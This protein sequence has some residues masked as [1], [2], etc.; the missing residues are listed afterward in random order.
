MDVRI[1]K[2]FSLLTVLKYYM[3][4]KNKW[5]SF[6]WSHWRKEAVLSGDINWGSGSSTADFCRGENA[7][8]TKDHA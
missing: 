1:K 4:F 2:Y 3:L 8:G 5:A 6:F 7:E